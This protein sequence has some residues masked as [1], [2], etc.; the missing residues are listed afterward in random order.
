MRERESE[1]ACEGGNTERGR[2]RLF[3]WGTKDPRVWNREEYYRLEK[4]S[5]YVFVDNL[6]ED[7]SKKEL[8]HLFG[9]TGKTIDIYLSRKRKQGLVYLFAFVR[10]T[11]KGAALKAITEMNHMRLRGKLLSI[12][13]AKFRRH[14]QERER[15][16]HVDQRVLYEGRHKGADSGS[17]GEPKESDSGKEG[18]IAQESEVN[19]D[20]AQ[21][22]DHSRKKRVDTAVAQANLEWLGRSVVGSTLKSFDIQSL[23][24]SICKIVP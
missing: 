20:D 22:A 9:W 10:Y 1:R 15:W 13:E 17:K 12:S 23:K 19:K 24:R 6:P 7:I 8:Y 5:F 14:L 4:E 18:V 11:T 16:V 2:L 3:Q 21:E